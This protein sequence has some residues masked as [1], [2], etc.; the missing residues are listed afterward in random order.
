MFKNYVLS[1]VRNFKK[2]RFYSIINILGLSFGI[3]AAAF[4][5]LYIT[6]EMGYDKHFTDHQKIYRL[7]SDFSINN[8]HDKFALTSLPLGPVFKTEMPEIESYARFINNEN[9]V[10]KYADKEFYEKKV[11]FADSAAPV[12][13]TLNFIEGDAKSSLVNPFTMIVSESTAKKYFGEGEAYG[14]TLVSGENR[15]YKITGIFKDLPQNTHMPFDILLSIESLAT[16]YGNDNFRSV[17]PESFWNVNSYTFI[18][19]KNPGDIAIIHERAKVFYVKYMKA[20]GDQLNATFNLMTTRLDQIHLTTKL[21]GDFP[22][23]NKSYMYLMGLVGIMILVLAAINYMNLATARATKRAREIGLRKVSGADR[24]QLAWQFVT[25]SLVLSVIAL[26]ISVALIQLLLPLFNEMADKHFKLD[27]FHNPQIYIMIAAIAVVTGL[28]SG[29][30]PAIYLS[31]FQPSNVL[32]GK[33]IIGRQSSWLRKGL[34]TFQLIISVIMITGTII[35]YNQLNYMRNADLGFK[36]ENVMVMEVQDTTFLKRM[37]S[38]RAELKENPNIV[39]TSM[40]RSVPGSGLSIQVMLVEKEG[41]MDEFV[42]NNIPCDQEFADLLGLEF[43]QGRNFSRDIKTDDTLSIIVNEATVRALEWGDDAI[44]KKINMDFGIDGKGGTPRK[45]IGVVKDFHFT[46]LHNKVEPLVLFIPRFPLN[47]LSV[48]LKEGSGANTIN[49]VKSK[50]ESFGNNR[51]FDY[52]FLDENF[53]NKYAAEAKLGKVFATFALL[54]IIIALMGLLGLS[55]FVTAQRTKE[56]GIRK[57]LGAS[58]EGIV[59]LLYK[60]SLILVIIA[61]IIALPISWYLISN[62]LDNY[63]YHI[64]F[65]WVTFLSATLTAIIIC[66]ASVSYHTLLAANSDPVKSIKY[67]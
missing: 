43:V 20:V 32:K 13:F 16:I 44:G 66:I 14:K 57:V 15:G 46:S 65:T 28:F 53:D 24:F 56:I 25:E 45:V 35:I 11:F 22:A 42:L 30:Y 38:F 10:F 49:F 19:L 39:A 52:Y 50:W 55:S 64:S 33:V 63:A 54:S 23:G 17:R 48:R 26:I 2:N 21:T 37:D 1:A 7:E 12:M 3:T 59:G 6:E 61:C 34:V 31:S 40:S 62:W 41:K 67:E 18:K 29:L 36:K 4:I 8:K 60:E 58:V 9:V 5:L 27:F 47:V 51:P